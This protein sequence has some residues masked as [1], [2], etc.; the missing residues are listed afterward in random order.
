MH[1]VV[2]FDW[3]LQ[4]RLRR[5][6][7]LP[8]LLSLFPERPPAFQQPL[9]LK[10]GQHE[11]RLTFGETYVEVQVMFKDPSDGFVPQVLRALLED[12]ADLEQHVSVCNPRGNPTWSQSTM[13]ELIDLHAL[14]IVD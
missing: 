4:K 14:H 10:N 6:A 13:Q 3:G 8:Q 11:A 2:L 1:G 12:P 5:P 7:S 9:V